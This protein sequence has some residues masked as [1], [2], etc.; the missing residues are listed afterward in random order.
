[1]S[2]KLGLVSHQGNSECEVD[3]LIKGGCAGLARHARVLGY[4]GGPIGPGPVI[5]LGQMHNNRIRYSVAS[6]CAGKL[7]QISFSVLIIGSTSSTKIKG[8]TTDQ[9]LN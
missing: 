9:K 8:S 2:I 6:Y 5:L 3:T 1:M 7:S 4:G